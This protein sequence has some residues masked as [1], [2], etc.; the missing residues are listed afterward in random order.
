M[1]NSVDDVIEALGG[2]ATVASLTG[3]GTSAVSN[4]SARRRIAQDKFVIVRDA[5]AALG[6][7]AS[8]AVF[9]F[10]VADEVRA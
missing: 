3:V 6:K 10:K 5:L 1:L 4:W 9:G 8:P 2:P 7:E